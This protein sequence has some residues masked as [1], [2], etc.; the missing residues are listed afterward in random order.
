V[1]SPTDAVLHALLDDVESR[2]QERVKSVK[3]IGIGLWPKQRALLRDESRRILA[4]G[5]RRSGKSIA[6]FARLAH[7]ARQHPGSDLAYVALTIK[8]SVRRI[9]NNL[10]RVLGT[11]VRVTNDG[12]AHFPEGSQIVIGGLEK[13]FGISRLRG[14]GWDGVVVDE[15]QEPADYKLS[16]LVESVIEPALADKNGWLILAGTPGMTPS[17]LWWDL[18]GARAMEPRVDADG[19]TRVTTGLYGQ[20]SSTAEWSMHHWRFAD[21][22]KKTQLADLEMKV[23]KGWSDTHPSWVRERLGEW[24][25]D[26]TH[27]AVPHFNEKRNLWR[28]GPTSKSNPFGLPE[29]YHWRYVCGMD[30]GFAFEPFVLQ[31][32]AYARNHPAVFQALERPLLRGCTVDQMARAYREAEAL[33]G[34][35]VGVVWDTQGPTGSALAD[36]LG[37]IH[38]IPGEK[39]QKT[40]YQ[41][42]LELLDSDLGEGRMFILEGS[43]LHHQMKTLIRDSKTGRVKKGQKD[44][45]FDAWRYVWS[46]TYHR[47]AEDRPPAKP[48]EADE[49]RRSALEL[50]AIQREREYLERVSAKKPNDPWAERNRGWK[51]DDTY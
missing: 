22:P 3:R 9:Q 31:V 14:E 30:L 19:M 28:R 29:G 8:D 16:Y 18:T 40:Q 25:W 10:A 34:S 36:A 13:L 7:H 27:A 20:S 50:Q 39:A 24:V 46:N 44:D 23:R 6:V 32:A 47:Y 35:F 15:V 26:P 5:R 42:W 12:V 48:L 2:K 51:P 17:G 45:A 37:S 38:R 43:Q 41:D 21:A 11:D 1:I 4:F 33:A 49:A